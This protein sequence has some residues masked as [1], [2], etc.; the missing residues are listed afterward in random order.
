MVTRRSCDPVG[1][2]ASASGWKVGE[3]VFD[4]LAPSFAQGQSCT[5]EVMGAGVSA[6]SHIA[7]LERSVARTSGSPRSLDQ[8]GWVP[9]PAHQRCNRIRDL[10]IQVEPQAVA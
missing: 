8:L 9:H 3:S 7:A 1:A 2:G 10:G 4:R 6:T 5:Y